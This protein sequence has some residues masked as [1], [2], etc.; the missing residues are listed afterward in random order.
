MT[1]HEVEIKTMQ[2][3]D[4]IDRIWGDL[5]SLGYSR[6]KKDEILDPHKLNEFDCYN[7]GGFKSA[8]NASK[9]LELNDTS[10]VLDFGAGIGGPARCISSFSGANVVGVELQKDLTDLAIELNERCGLSKKIQMVAG[11]FLNND[12]DSHYKSE[13]NTFDAV[14][15]W[16]VI[17]HIPF[18]SRVATFQKIYNLLKPGGKVY[19]EDYYAKFELN[20]D[21]KYKLAND[22]YVPQGTLPSKEQYINTM[23]EAGFDSNK[24]E[25]NDAS[26]EWNGFTSE[27][28]NI[29]QSKKERHIKVY[30]QATYDNLNHFYSSVSGLFDAG[31][32]G[33]A[34]IILTK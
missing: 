3:Y 23:I 19:I 27:R 9:L 22:V 33:G 8:Q 7:Y 25:F 12:L 17:L 10:L 30:N 28:L 2:L 6:D 14:V 11:D 4:D 34:K 24:I 20:D 18:D 29:F 13:P 1:N 15:S 26:E 16:L 32:L 5:E 21:D 31:R